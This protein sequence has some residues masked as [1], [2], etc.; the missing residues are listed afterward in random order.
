LQTLVGQL[1]DQ[2][3]F[4]YRANIPEHRLRHDQL[5]QAIEAWNESTQTAQ[6]RQL[7]SQ[8][9]RDAMAASMPGGKQALPPLPDFGTVAE[10]PAPQSTTSNKPIVSDQPAVPM[11]H[12]ADNQPEFRDD[13]PAQTPPVGIEPVE[14]DSPGGDDFWGDYPAE[15][16]P[17]ESLVPNDNPF[18]DDPLGL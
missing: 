14:S 7:M 9:L 17:T 3:W 8:W 18:G 13:A 15:T 1:S 4:A 10:L 6:D 11:E 2:F 5:R 12:P 16:E